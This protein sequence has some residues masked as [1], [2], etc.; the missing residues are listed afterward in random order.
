[1]EL[2]LCWKQDRMQQP[3]RA[4]LTN[5]ARAHTTS[6]PPPSRSRSGCSE[7]RILHK[8]SQDGFWKL[9]SPVSWSCSWA[10]AVHSLGPQQ[11]C[12]E[13]GLLAAEPGRGWCS[14]RRLGCCGQE[15]INRADLGIGSYAW[16]PQSPGLQLSYRILRGLGCLTGTWASR[17]LQKFSL[18]RCD[19]A[20]P[21]YLIIFS[22]DLLLLNMCRHGKWMFIYKERPWQNQG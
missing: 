15:G 20:T 6:P 1:M 18:F 21:L 13:Q 10:S 4:T 9:H 12:G 3:S 22:L 17:L 8:W 14:A 7:P 11:V 16:I 19:D 2:V 5:P